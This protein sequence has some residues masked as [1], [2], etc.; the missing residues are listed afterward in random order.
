MWHGLR[1]DRRLN[2]MIIAT[3]SLGMATCMTAFAIWAQLDADPLP[4]HSAGLQ[5]VQFDAR[6]RAELED[7]DSDRS[8]IPGLLTAVDGRQLLDVLP[9]QI[10][11]ALMFDSQLA[12]ATGDLSTEVPALIT[13]RD[14][15]AL[16]GMRLRQG[17]VWSV[18]DEMARRPLAV[19]TAALA[20]RLFGTASVVGRSIDLQGKP[21]T[22]VGVV[23]DWK[24]RLHF[25]LPESGL[26]RHAAESLFVSL[27]AA[28]ALDYVVDGS[29]ACDHGTEL[30]AVRPD[31][32]HCRWM[33]LWVQADSDAAAQA[34]RERL[35]AYAAQQ[36]A[37]GRFDW[38]PATALTPLSRWLLRYRAVPADVRLGTVLAVGLYAICLANMVALLT[39]RFLFR[40]AEFGIRRAL[41]ARRRVVFGHCLGEAALLAALSVA[42]AVPLLWGALRL[43]RDQ[44]AAWAGFARADGGQFLMLALV[45]L[46]ACLA[47]AAVPAWRASRIAPALQIRQ[48]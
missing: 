28:D 41:G 22:I 20:E 39:A 2:L 5:V 25:H 18:D 15:F 8:R 11:R 3:L 10:P 27:P 17:A 23:D 9:T 24:P 45:T 38:A 48:L 36:H 4:G 46:A 16:F 44:P 43:I 7:P 31:P 19:I 26:Y 29:W 47:V 42:M 40:S 21:F 32:L 14:V 35:A 34:L 13:T 33:A 30:R 6:Q 12:V 1:R 37:L